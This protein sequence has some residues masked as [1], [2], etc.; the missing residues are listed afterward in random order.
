VLCGYIE[1][2]IFLTK[3]INFFQWV[4]PSSKGMSTLKKKFHWVKV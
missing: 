1:F 4:Y 3:S 2:D